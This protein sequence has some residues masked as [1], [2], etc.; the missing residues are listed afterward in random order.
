MRPISRP[1][2]PAHSRP[3]LDPAAQADPAARADRAPT[4]HTARAPRGPRAPRRTR[5]CGL[6]YGYPY[7]RPHA[8]S[9]ATGTPRCQGSD[10]VSPGFR[11]PGADA[12]AVVRELVPARRATSR[13][14]GWVV[15]VLAVAAAGI[16]AL[17]LRSHAAEFVHSLNRALNAN[18]KLVL[19]AALLEAGSVAGYVLLLHRVLGGASSRLRV[20]DSYDI[21]LAGAAATRLLPTAGLGGAAVTVWALQARGMRP[22]E[23]AERLLAFMLLI[24]AVYMA[25]LISTGAA[26]ASGAVAVSSGR[27]LGALGAAVAV[28][29]V[30]AVI[31]L[32]AAPA[33]V[34]A[35]LDRLARRPGRL[36]RVATRVTGQLP[37][38]RRGL[39][40]ASAELR[41]PHPALLGALAWWAL[42]VGVLV[43]ML[44]AFGVKLSIPVVVLAYFLGT[45][46]NVVPLPG[47]LSGGLAAALIALGC[48][49]GAAIAAVLAYRAIAVWLPALPG[50][51]SLGG[52]RASVAAWRADPPAVGLTAPPKARLPYMPHRPARPQ[53]MSDLRH[54]QG[55]ANVVT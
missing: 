32:L 36:G 14:R 50:I 1:R 2:P 33:P 18:W 28:A 11:F 27:D 43:V 46:F 24:Y 48:P 47:S 34:A 35:A 51:V 20:K 31:V 54:L 17:L 23:I 12:L 55:E 10:V 25:A 13:R 5:A 8:S 4:P 40:R 45:T 16:F 37:V 15:P 3:P 9:I 6:W 22:S 44:H 21:T 29:L 39:L 30:G 26:V 7:Q 41:R 19:L 53:F 38:L 49:V 42:D 52:L